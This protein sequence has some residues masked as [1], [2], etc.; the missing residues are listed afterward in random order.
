VFVAE[1]RLVVRRLLASR[2]V[3][4]SVMVTAT[5]LG[6][7]AD[8]IEAQPCLP[9]FVVA[10]EVMNAIAGFNIHR[11]CLASVSVR[12]RDPGT[13]WRGKGPRRARTGRQRR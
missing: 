2:F 4:R 3:T 7:V 12:R 1:G 10:Q 13:S 8:L 11:G 5:A 6:A 9:V